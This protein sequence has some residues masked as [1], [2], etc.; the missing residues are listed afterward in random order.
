M[1]NIATVQAT[2]LA[3]SSPVHHTLK[4]WNAKQTNINFF[5][6]CCTVTCICVRTYSVVANHKLADTP[7][8][9]RLTLTHPLLDGKSVSCVN[10][11]WLGRVST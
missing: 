2:V 11:D 6:S 7:M 5:P 4:E 1:A 8:K 3:M 10:V 9:E